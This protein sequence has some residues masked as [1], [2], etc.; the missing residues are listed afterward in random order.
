M[1][2]QHQKTKTGQTKVQMKELIHLP[3]HTELSNTTK[4]KQLLLL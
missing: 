1:A 3:E 4:K 2:L